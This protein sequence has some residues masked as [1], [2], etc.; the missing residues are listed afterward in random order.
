MSP[1]LDEKRRN[2]CPKCARGWMG[3]STPQ[4]TSKGWV[5][6]LNEIANEEYERGIHGLT[7]R[8]WK[9]RELVSQTLSDQKQ[10]ILDRMEEWIYE[11]R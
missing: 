10:E 9:I 2:Q 8:A 3:S 11:E 1:T 5:K 6:R 4:E 7:F